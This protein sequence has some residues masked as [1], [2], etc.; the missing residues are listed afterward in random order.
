MKIIALLVVLLICSVGIS[1]ATNY[2]VSTT[3]NNAS[4]G[5]TV[6]TAWL[7][8]SYAAT[9]AS[10]GD[11]IYILNGTW[12]ED[13]ILFT[14]NGTSE[15]P[16]VMR[17]YNGTPILNGMSPFLNDIVGF[18]FLSKE[19]ITI[20]GLN[21]FNYSTCLS[22]NM[23][24]NNITILDSDFSVSYS[25]A[26]GLTGNNILFDNCSVHHSGWNGIGTGGNREPPNGD[27]TPSTYISITNC[28]IYNNY[29]HG[30]IDVFGNIDYLIIENN[31]IRDS[32]STAFYTHSQTDI[33][34]NVTIR[35]NIM[36]N[37]TNGI[38][39]EN[40]HDSIISDNWI[41]D[42]NGTSKFGIYL[43]YYSSNVTL[44]N[45][46][47]STAWAG[48]SYPIA[49]VDS[50]VTMIGNALPDKNMYS[51]AQTSNNPITDAIGSYAVVMGLANITVNYTDNRVFTISRN[52]EV[53]NTVSDI[54]YTPTNSEINANGSCI[55]SVFPHNFTITPNSGYAKDVIINTE[56]ENDFSSIDIN[57]SEASIVTMT[58][59]VD[60]ATQTYNLTVDNI[61]ESNAI[62]NE[63]K[64]VAFNYTFSSAT[65]KEFNVS[66]T[67]TSGWIAD[68]A[69][70]VGYECS[71]YQSG[72]IKQ[73]HSIQYGA[74]SLQNVFSMVVI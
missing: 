44:L 10:A 20:R 15:N 51:I 49:S 13:A 57:V 19:Y 64:I 38:K 24:S 26:V 23:N 14:N 5:L 36:Y 4:N 6:E 45:N 52:T 40:M 72:E 2:Y 16:I 42:I 22:V 54:I 11:T 61:F 28:T 18:N 71:T 12:Y 62:S 55:L 9:Q 53:G 65:S 70:Y 31:T 58:C 39:I 67:S 33:A 43:S 1:S 17:A 21:V 50:N 47:V 56:N 74:T 27:G 37:V 29:L 73:K 7:N 32:P 66:W 59:S 68:N 60:N 35:N 46:N 69:Q 48:S 3:G 41:Y 25:S 63:D 34:S 30:G 8:P